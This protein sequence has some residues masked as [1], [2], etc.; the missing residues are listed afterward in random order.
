MK[1]VNELHAKIGLPI[2]MAFEKC[3]LEDFIDN[4]ETFL[5]M[6]PDCKQEHW[7]FMKFKDWEHYFF[8]IHLN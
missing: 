2:N 4:Q 1:K 6:V 8:E 3:D 7:D 5:D